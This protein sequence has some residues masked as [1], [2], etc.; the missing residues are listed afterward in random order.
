MPVDFVALSEKEMRVASVTVATLT[1][2]L[3]LR[4]VVRVFR[5][6]RAGEPLVVLHKDA[7]GAQITLPQST[8]MRTE[9]YWAAAAA[10]VLHMELGEPAAERVIAFLGQKNGVFE[11]LLWLSF[12]TDR[13]QKGTSLTN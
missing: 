12:R 10:L 5:A 8:L 7:A 3:D 13:A 6:L 9:R 4:R 11:A 1:E 2:Q